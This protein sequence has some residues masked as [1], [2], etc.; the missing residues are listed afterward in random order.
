MF[1]EQQLT[2]LNAP[3]DRKNV[4]SRKQGSAQVSYIE[5]WHAIAE[6]NRI[7]GFGEWV[8]ET[9]ENKCVAEHPYTIGKG[10]NWEKEGHSVTYTARVRITVNGEDSK[11]VAREGFGAGH[12]ID[13]SLGQAHESAI[14]EAETDAMKRALMTFGNPFGLALYD[15]AQIN[16]NNGGENG[17][18]TAPS[19]SYVS[20]CIATLDSSKSV[21]ELKEH[22]SGIYQAENFKALSEEQK[23]R[24]SGTKDT[25]KAILEKETV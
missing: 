21:G 9:V 15:K 7:F 6:A 25:R 12:G 23:Q 16:V 20:T 17:Q 19:D 11:S 18:A 22:F 1:T 4:K 8:R 24:I 10:K 5:G 2:K 13:Q 3:L 14:K